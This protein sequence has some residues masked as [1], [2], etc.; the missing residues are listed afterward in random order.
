MRPEQVFGEQFKGWIEVASACFLFLLD[1]YE[2]ENVDIR[3]R[4]PLRT[5]KSKRAARYVA[6]R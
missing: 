1:I 4:K 2:G 6:E 3:H 5:L